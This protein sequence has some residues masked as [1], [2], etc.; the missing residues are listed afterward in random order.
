MDVLHLGIALIPLAVYLLVIGIANLSRRPRVTSGGR[1]SA[2][3]GLGLSGFL[4]AG[5]MELLLPESTA[6][7]LGSHVYVWGLMLALYGLGLILLVLSGRPRLIIYNARQEQLRPLLAEVAHQLDPD[8]RWAGNCLWLPRIGV[9]L[10]LEPARLMRLVQLVSAGNRQNLLGWRML[11]EALVQRLQGEE[12][13][14]NPIGGMMVGIAVALTT[15]LGVRMV[16]HS[17]EVAQAVREM[18]RL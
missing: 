3:L 14:P 2:A 17:A 8:A 5:P 6:E 18:L 9:Q 16:S 15:Y 7:R 1:D 10:H 12:S 4:V 11:E 13:R